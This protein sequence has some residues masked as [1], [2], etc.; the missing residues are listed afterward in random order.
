MKYRAFLL[1]LL[2]GMTTHS[3][4]QSYIQAIY[5][6]LPNENPPP[7]SISQQNLVHS[8]NDQHYIIAIEYREVYVAK[9]D[10]SGTP[11][12]EKKI[13]LYEGGEE[14]FLAQI[15]GIA[16]NDNGVVISLLTVG[17]AWNVADE[18]VFFKFSESGELLWSYTSPYFGSILGEKENGGLVFRFDNDA[19][20]DLVLSTFTGG[21][22][23]QSGQAINHPSWIDGE[24]NLNDI[25]SEDY[26]IYNN[27]YEGAAD[28]N[29]GNNTILITRY[30]F[31]TETLSQS[32]FYT[33]TLI[34][35][36][37]EASNR[38]LFD[39]DGGFYRSFSF[40]NS[41]YVAKYDSEG[42]T[43]WA[44]QA[45]RPVLN[46]LIDGSELLLTVGKYF[47]NTE[48]QVIRIDKTSGTILSEIKHLGIASGRSHFPMLNQDGG[49]TTL[50]YM[51]D[52]VSNQ[53]TVVLL[54]K[55]S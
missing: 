41:S 8:D 23:F 3:Y 17:T 54:F 14:H 46:I 10:I 13:T 9:L 31:D 37:V 19:D 5:P 39:A 38:I 21:G 49:F 22:T 24:S 6:V 2:M 25:T 12:W 45:E 52:F 35:D 42:N 33:E 32:Y 7:L 30:N 53:S 34:P 11:I 28:P 44:Y 43:V 47:P 48:T 4:T 18:F 36:S 50:A 16:T 26:I 15:H 1:C 55:Y 40:I 29:P 51:H 27:I 20:A